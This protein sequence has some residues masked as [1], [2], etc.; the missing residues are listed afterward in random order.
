MMD[1]RRQGVSTRAYMAM[2]ESIV[3]DTEKR[4]EWRSKLDEIRRDKPDHA[5]FSWSFNFDR[6]EYERREKRGHNLPKDIQYPPR[7]RRREPVDHELVARLKGR[8]MHPAS[9]SERKLIYE[10]ISADNRGRYEYLRQRRSH[11]PDVRYSFPVT[12]SM[13]YGWNLYD[14]NHRMVKDEAEQSDE[15]NNNEAVSLNSARN[16]IKNVIF[17]DF[18]RSN[19]AFPRRDPLDIKLGRIG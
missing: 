3:R 17:A 4:C 2:E 12:S 14:S 1:F 19:G 15:A 18:Y 11:N 7:Q 10:G 13:E 6:A 16:G 8:D 5:Q 9:D